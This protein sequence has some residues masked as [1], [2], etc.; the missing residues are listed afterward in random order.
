MTIKALLIARDPVGNRAPLREQFEF[1]VLPR[2]GEQIAV[3]E[4]ERDL[5]IEV[6]SITHVPTGPSALANEA[7]VHVRGTI[8][9]YS[10]QA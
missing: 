1:A 3:I 10:Y 4:I 9:D 2:A 8:L 6:A 5:L 7:E